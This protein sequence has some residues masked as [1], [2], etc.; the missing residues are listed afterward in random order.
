MANVFYKEVVMHVFVILDTLE[1]SVMK[2]LMNALV[3]L[4]IT[5]E[6]VWIR[7]VNMNVIA[8]RSFMVK[9]LI[10]YMFIASN[11]PKGFKTK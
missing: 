11:F 2:K 5:K 1:N 10:L 6:S 4:V 9:H 3:S 8:P 7:L